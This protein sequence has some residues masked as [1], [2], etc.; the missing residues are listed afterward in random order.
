MNGFLQSVRDKEFFFFFFFFF[1]N[2]EFF[3][4]FRN[5]K[6]VSFKFSED[7][8]NLQLEPY[9]VITKSKRREEHSQFHIIP[10]IR[11]LSC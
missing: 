6:T 5:S 7:I 3:L 10:S 9:D 4:N 2:L 8:V 1:V 11:I